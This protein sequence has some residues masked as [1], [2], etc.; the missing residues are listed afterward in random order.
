MTSNQSHRKYCI[1]CV[2][3]DLLGLEARAAVL[4]AAG[5]SV[6]AVCCPL[7][8]LGFEV[9][10]FH[11]A[12]IDFDLPG[13]NGFQLF[14]RLRAAHASFPI[15]LLSGMI[16]DLPNDIRRVFSICLD[17][18]DPIHCLLDT[19]NSYLTAVPDP[20]ECHALRGARRGLYR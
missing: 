14:L 6:T 8:A 1:L 17:K 13:L 12:V 3:D 11:L 19:I 18:G 15:V 2:D 4:E 10:K 7:K 20:P 9:S 16:R 5:Y